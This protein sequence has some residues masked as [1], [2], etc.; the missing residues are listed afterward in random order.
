[1]GI[2]TAGTTK[3]IIKDEE[4]RGDRLRFTIVKEVK[5]RTEDVL[6]EGRVN[7]NSIKGSVIFKHGPMAKRKR[8]KAKRNAYTVTPLDNKPRQIVLD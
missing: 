8:W 3:M 1:M 2:M 6:F 7:G 4:L 5:G